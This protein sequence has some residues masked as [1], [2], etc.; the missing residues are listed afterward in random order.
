MLLDLYGIPYDSL[1]IIYH[2][3][4]KNETT[5][6]TRP[7]DSS[8]PMWAPQYAAQ[9]TQILEDHYSYGFRMDSPIEI[10]RFRNYAETDAITIPDSDEELDKEIA[11]AGILID[12]KI[13]AFEDSVLSEL[14]EL[15]KAVFDSGIG[16]IFL[17]PFIDRNTEWLEEHYISSA[18]MVKALLFKKCPD[19]YY[20]QN[21]V[22]AGEK[23]TEHE[24]MVCT[25]AAPVA[26]SPS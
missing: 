17:E 3:R 10:M 12:G 21:I 1:A 24:S 15:V 8:I 23:K 19:F 9:V 16:V 22:T 20:G 14:S 5:A 7:E 6:S 18:E 13:F 25:E 26:F 4:D 11:S 2:K